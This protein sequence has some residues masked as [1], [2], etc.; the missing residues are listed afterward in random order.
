MHE[1]DRTPLVLTTGRWL[2]SKCLQRIPI[3]AESCPQCG[4]KS[5]KIEY[6]PAALAEADRRRSQ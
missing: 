2:C 3:G 1:S 4:G 5:F 6:D